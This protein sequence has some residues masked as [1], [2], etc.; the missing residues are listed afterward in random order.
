MHRGITCQRVAR[1]ATAHLEAAIEQQ[2][3]EDGV[4]HGVSCGC[5]AGELEV[6]G[7]RE[8]DTALHNVISNER[9]Q[10][11]SSRGAEHRGTMRRTQLTLHE[12]VQHLKPCKR[13]EAESRRR[14]LAQLGSDCLVK[15]TACASV[16]QGEM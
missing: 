11:T 15:R 9:P 5:R 6:A 12:R 10:D 13:A 16:Q 3:K 4:Q 1:V 8:D 14:P 2:A 7:T